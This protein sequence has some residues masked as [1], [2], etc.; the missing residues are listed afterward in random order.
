MKSV[1]FNLRIGCD[2]DDCIFSFYDP[3]LKRFGTP[4]DDFEITRNVQRILRKDRDF[5]LNQPV[6]NVPDFNVTLYCTKRVHP[7]SWT[8]KQL[9]IH[10]LPE[11]PV[12][13]MYS[14]SGNKATMIKGR[15]DVFIDD[16][17]SNFIK[18]NLSGVPC[19]LIDSPYNQDWGP[20]GRIYS[21][22]IAEIQ[23]TYRLFMETIFNNFSKLL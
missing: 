17:I 20:I 22:S 9:Q 3:Y 5:W 10:G 15:V 21:L 11:A 12:Y 13:Q 19:L 6:I 2:L 14:Q 16:S 18:M 7:K 23:S 8:K 4:K 1:N